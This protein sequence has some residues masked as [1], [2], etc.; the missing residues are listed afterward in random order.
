M[1]NPPVI[2]NEAV[3][4]HFRE[5]E[6]WAKAKLAAESEPPWA[7]Y[8]YMKLRDAIASIRAMVTVTATEGSPESDQRQGKH[9]RL[10]GQ[11]YPQDTPPRHPDPISVQLP[12]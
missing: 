8:Q 9:L 12:M 4:D 7:W 1:S 6:D 11:D 10:V 2:T 3:L 5:L